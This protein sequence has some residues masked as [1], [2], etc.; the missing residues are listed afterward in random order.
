VET[1]THLQLP[2]D[3]SP[4]KSSP[5]CYGSPTSQQYQEVQKHSICL[6]KRKLPSKDEERHF[7]DALQFALFSI[8][9][10]LYE[11]RSVLGVSLNQEQLNSPRRRRQWLEEA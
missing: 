10:L 6:G 7:S 1:V 4:A 5:N 11:E 8:L 9:Q 3:K 2:V